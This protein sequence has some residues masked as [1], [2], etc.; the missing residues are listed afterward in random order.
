[1]EMFGLTV[2]CFYGAS[3]ILAERRESSSIQSAVVQNLDGL[4]Q[5]YRPGN[6]AGD[7]QRRPALRGEL[8]DRSAAPDQRDT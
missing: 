4:G 5:D 1:M 8:K 6:L 2:S 3:R 7:G